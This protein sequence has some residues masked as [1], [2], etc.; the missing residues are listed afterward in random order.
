MATLTEAAG[1]WGISALLIWALQWRHRAKQT[2]RRLSE[3]LLRKGYVKI[4][5]VDGR[6]K[7]IAWHRILPVLERSWQ[8][9]AS[10]FSQLTTAPDGRTKPYTVTETIPG[11][12]LLVADN[13][14]VQGIVA[15]ICDPGLSFHFGS[16]THWRLRLLM[17]PLWAWSFL[18]PI[19]GLFGLDQSWHIANFPN[20]LGMEAGTSVPLGCHIDSGP[21]AKFGELTFGPDKNTGLD[22]ETAMLFMAVEQMAVLLYCETPGVLGAEEGSTGLCPFSHIVLL[23]SIRQLA[24]SKTFTLRQVLAAIKEHVRAV[25]PWEQSPCKHGTVPGAVDMCV[26]QLRI[27]EDEGVLMMGSTIHTAMWATRSMQGMPRIIQ[28]CKIHADW[29]HLGLGAE[30][31]FVKALSGDSPIRRLYTSPMQILPDLTDNE[32]V[33]VTG[34]VEA[35][36]A[37]LKSV[38]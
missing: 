24:A 33:F 30:L 27:N 6:T 14:Y 7:R 35:L 26:E 38:L 16:R 19:P 21:L 5:C 37:T 25:S 18:A 4:P 2:L 28:N 22:L 11:L 36:V 10:S 31:A 20:K 9:P 8:T 1:L 3:E 15:T 34:R 29:G 13:Y 17:D 12:P 23:E 32:S